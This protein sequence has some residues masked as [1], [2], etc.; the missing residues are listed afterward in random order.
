M[1]IDTLTIKD[2][3]TGSCLLT[4]LILKD[5][6]TGSYLF[7]SLILIKWHIFNFYSQNFLMMG[8]GYQLCVHLRTTVRTPLPLISEPK[9][10]FEILGGGMPLQ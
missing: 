7:I 3:S 6:A 1:L 9:I 5:T 8:S 4:P 2:T 10:N